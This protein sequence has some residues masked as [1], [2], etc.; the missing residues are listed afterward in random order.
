[1]GLNLKTREHTRRFH[2]DDIRSCKI[3]CVCACS[4]VL[5]FL[6]LV[7][8]PESRYGKYWA[9]QGLLVLLF[10]LFSL[11]VGFIVGGLL[12]LMAMIPFIGIVFHI[13]KIV[14]IVAI[15]AL[16]LFVIVL[17]GSFA[18]RGRARDLPLIG[19]LRLI[20]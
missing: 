13:I 11:L 20:K 19:H 15:C 6:P 12:G 3:E 9:N 8:V 14:A 17:A 7:S 16:N 2:P 1:M 4:G 18:A 10:E 5:F